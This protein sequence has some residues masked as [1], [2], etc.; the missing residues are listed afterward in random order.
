MDIADKIIQGTFDSDIYDELG[1]P[2]S[3]EGE[4][5]YLVARILMRNPGLYLDPLDG[6]FYIGVR[7]VNLTQNKLVEL[8]DHYNGWCKGGRWPM[9]VNR[10]RKFAPQLDRSKIYISKHLMWDMDNHKLIRK[11]NG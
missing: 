8:A 10:L 6:K 9:V 7:E 2:L 4:I 3:A 1:L 5:D 11:N